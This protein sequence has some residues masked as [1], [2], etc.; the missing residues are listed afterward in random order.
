MCIF[1]ARARSSTS[2]PFLHLI[3]ASRRMGNAK[4][5]SLYNSKSKSKA[6]DEDLCKAPPDFGEM[7]P[8]LLKQ[9][10]QTSYL[11]LLPQE[12]RSVWADEQLLSPDRLF[13]FLGAGEVY[14]VLLVDIRP[15]SQAAL[16]FRACSTS[17][18]RNLL[19]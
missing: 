19:L 8:T 12:I 2:A 11:R 15:T 9:P 17:S 7:F 14:E 4:S 5:K 6:S 3:S 16:A 13:F 1:R 18:R 10:P